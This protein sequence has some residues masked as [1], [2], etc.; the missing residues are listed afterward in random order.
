MAAPAPTTAVTVQTVH[1]QTLAQT[2]TAY[3]QL[4]PNPQALRWL[5]AALAGRVEAVYV[6]VGATV[7]TGQ[8]LAFIKP[9]PQTLATFQSA[10][11]SLVAAQSKLKQ[12]KTLAQNGLAT[13]SDLA[14]AKSAVETAKSLLTA[15]QSEGVSSHG[16]TLKAQHAGVVTQLAITP[17]QWVSAG[18]RIAALAPAGKL[19]VRLGLTPKQA[20]H[21]KPGESVRLAPVFGD[22]RAAGGKVAHVA[23]QANPKTGLIDADVPVSAAG[24][25]FFPGEW[26]TGTIVLRRL[27]L[28]T[29]PR[30]AVLKDKRGYYVFVVRGGKAHRVAVEP[31]VRAHGLVGLRGI[32]PGARV[33][34]QGNFELSNGAAVRI[35]PPQTAPAPAS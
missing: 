12:T 15:L 29:V 14:A 31:R 35:A 5:S 28:P 24:N 20:A 6:T 17:G 11:S 27:K 2:V 30:S 25:G 34:T 33:V 1:V 3:G 22:G 10:R 13:R 4:V 8:K 9:T 26:V 32:A 19:W 18:A 16:E 21:V 23:G 7:G